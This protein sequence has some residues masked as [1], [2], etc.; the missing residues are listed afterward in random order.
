MKKS[1]QKSLEITV[2]ANCLDKSPVVDQAISGPRTLEAVRQAAI[3]AVDKMLQDPNLLDGSS[4][5][6]LL[7]WNID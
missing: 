5:H 6:I 1:T 4:L 7:Q 3:L 2:A